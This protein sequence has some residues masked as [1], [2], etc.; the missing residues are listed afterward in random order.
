MN[1]NINKFL[2]T[3]NIDYDLDGTIC[4]DFKRLLYFRHSNLE[5]EKNIKIQN[6]IYEYVNKYNTDRIQS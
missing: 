5:E 2:D 3:L 6:K 1:I 4:N